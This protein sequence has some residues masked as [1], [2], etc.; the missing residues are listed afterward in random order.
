MGP[1]ASWEMNGR[2]PR[3]G[4]QG[5]LALGLL[6]GLLEALES[7]AVV[8]EVESRVFAKDVDQA[9]HDALVEVLAAEVGV[10]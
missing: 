8:A 5:E 10:S 7:H 6:G 3:F 2:D 4:L 9:V 1:D